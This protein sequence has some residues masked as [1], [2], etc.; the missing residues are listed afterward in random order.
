MPR[1]VYRTVYVEVIKS[2]TDAEE[3]A[4]QARQN[5]QTEAKNLIAEA[6]KKGREAVSEAIVR[7]EAEN[8]K[9]MQAAEQ[10]AVQNAGKLETDTTQFCSNLRAE[11]RRRLDE[12][13]SVIAERIVNS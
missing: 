6:E 8:K 3:A 9:R 12:A 1:E 13:A 11:S 10:K 4:R 5:A 2:I 7:A